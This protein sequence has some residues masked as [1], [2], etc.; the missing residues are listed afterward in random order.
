MFKFS[1][2]HKED[3]FLYENIFYNV[4]NKTFLEIGACDG[5]MAS[6]TL[7]FEKELNWNGILIE[8]NPYQYKHLQKNRPN[9]KLFTTLISDITTPCK[10]QCISNEAVSGVVST[11]PESHSTF[12]SKDNEHSYWRNKEKKIV[13]LQP[14]TMQSILDETNMHNID[15]FSLDVEGHELNVLKSIDFS[16]NTINVI[17]VE[18]LNTNSE[19][20]KIREFLKEKNYKFYD[21]V[22]RNEVYILNIFNK[23]SKISN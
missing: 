5:L 4:K 22:G 19:L 15:L 9:N 2:R 17:L 21:I 23:I 16:K 11:L 18:M 8:A 3:K 10:Y 7:F 20:E 1:G 6:N 14:R 13:T 12:F